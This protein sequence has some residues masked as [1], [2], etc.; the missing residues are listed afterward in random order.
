MKQ[1]S[2]GVEEIA[3]AI[4]EK[5]CLTVDSSVPLICLRVKGSV[6]VSVQV[7]V[8]DNASMVQCHMIVSS[9]AMHIA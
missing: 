3:D 1:L 9:V 5:N 4:V 7:S 2:M 8:D 6:R